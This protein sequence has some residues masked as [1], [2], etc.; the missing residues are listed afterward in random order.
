MLNYEEAIWFFPCNTMLVRK[1]TQTLL[2]FLTTHKNWNLAHT[3]F[4][5]LSRLQNRTK[6]T[7]TRFILLLIKFTEDIFLKLLST[8][9]DF[10][11]SVVRKVCSSK[12]GRLSGGHKIIS[13]IL[14]DLNA[15]LMSS[16]YIS[17][18][19]IMFLFI[20][21]TTQRLVIFVVISIISIV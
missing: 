1:N 4:L 20:F 17:C 5:S 16:L 18:Y 21:L 9:A 8:N 7:R 12:Q 10:P 11:I 14:C 19:E 3:I 2:C 13:K 15:N 6:H